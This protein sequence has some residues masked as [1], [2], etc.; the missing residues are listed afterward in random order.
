M[1]PIARTVGSV[2]AVTSLVVAFA[3]AAQAQAYAPPQTAGGL[4]WV[5]ALFVGVA[6]VAV[7]V[8]VLFLVRGPTPRQ[9]GEPPPGAAQRRV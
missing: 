6:V 9:P 8:L 4:A 1:T 3:A 5:F 7:F 2:L